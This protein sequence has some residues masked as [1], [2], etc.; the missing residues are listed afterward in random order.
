MNP[1]VIE[2][3]C[4]IRDDDNDNYSDIEDHGDADGDGDCFRRIDCPGDG[5]DDVAGDVDDEQGDCLCFLARDLVIIFANVLHLY[6]HCIV[7]D[8]ARLLQSCYGCLMV[9]ATLRR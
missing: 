7:A 2:H 3:L 4:M 1:Y 8:V 5:Y 9:I 6:I